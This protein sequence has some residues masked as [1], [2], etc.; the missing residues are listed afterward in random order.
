M[1]PFVFSF[2][3]LT[4]HSLQLLSLES[5]LVDIHE[6]PP[7]A[8]FLFRSV[9]LSRAL[10]VSPQTLR[11]LILNASETDPVEEIISDAVW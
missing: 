10:K 11:N 8:H 7:F 6:C 4:Y 3:I 5:L 9:F 1:I 2:I